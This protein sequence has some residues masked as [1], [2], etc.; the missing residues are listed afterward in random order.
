[1]A[2]TIKSH[3]LSYLRHAVNHRNKKLNYISLPVDK[4]E[5]ILEVAGK[6]QPNQSEYHSRSNSVK[7]AAV[8]LAMDV[9]ELIERLNC[10]TPSKILND[11][12]EA[13]N[14]LKAMSEAGDILARTAPKEAIKEWVRAKSL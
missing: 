11:L 12:A 14:R 8:V 4:A 2:R 10:P 13:R 5:E 6:F 7:G 9:K 1:M 3:G